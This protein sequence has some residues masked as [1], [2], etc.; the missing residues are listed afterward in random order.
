MSL[1]PLLIAPVLIAGLALA[2]PASAALDSLADDDLLW[3]LLGYLI[4]A[5]FFWLILPLIWLLV[6]LPVAILR[7]LVSS[8]RWVEALSTWPNE[9]KLIWKTRRGQAAAVAE[10]VVAK[11]PQGYE[12]LTPVGAELVYMTRPPGL[13]DLDR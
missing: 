2:L 1:R 4:L 12:D 5:P 9:L 10:H 13:D 8:T 11:L 7:P 6:Q 3:S